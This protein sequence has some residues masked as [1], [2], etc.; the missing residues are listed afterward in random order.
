MSSALPKHA[1][2]VDNLADVSAAD[3]SLFTFRSVSSLTP[4]PMLRANHTRARARSSISIVPAAFGGGA[5]N[6]FTSA[7][8]FTVL[9]RGTTCAVGAGRLEGV[10]QTEVGWLTGAGWSW[11]IVAPE[12]PW[13]QRQ[14]LQPHQQHLQ[15][16]FE[17]QLEQHMPASSTAGRQPQKNVQ[18]SA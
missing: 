8:Y 13:L 10:M 5:R 7:V 12:R 1:D 14:Q 11:L 2:D 4:Y 16:Q 17:Q 9:P 15:A 18:F 6:V 3:N